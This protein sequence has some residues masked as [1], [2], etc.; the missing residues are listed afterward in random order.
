MKNFKSVN[1]SFGFPTSADA[2]VR[3][4]RKSLGSQFTSKEA[5]AAR[6]PGQIVRSHFRSKPVPGPKAP[7]FAHGGPV[8]KVVG[9]QGHATV[10]RSKPVTAFDAAAGGKGPLRTGY[11]KGGRIPAGKLRARMGKGKNC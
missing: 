11:A 10:Q 8:T 3:S 9:D 7:Q 1:K 2:S 6:S 5:A 4:M